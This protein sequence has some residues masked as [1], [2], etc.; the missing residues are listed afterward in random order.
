MTLLEQLEQFIL[1]AKNQ[2]KQKAAVRPAAPVQPV[3]QPAVFEVCDLYDNTVR[4]H[5]KQI[6]A[7][8]RAFM[9]FKKQNPMIPANKR[10]SSAI[11]GG[12]FS[13]AVPGM[14]KAHLTLDI[15]VW[16]TV[17]GADPRIIKLYAVMTHEESGTGEPAKISKQLTVA[18]KMKS[19]DFRPM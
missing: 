15:S 12:P 19:Q 5:R 3:N 14:R 2:P 17:T 4:V 18:D 1:E 6:E 7:K 11:G 13:M 9:D 16:Y 8:L 10:D